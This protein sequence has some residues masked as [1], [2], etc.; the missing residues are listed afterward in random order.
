[1]WVGRAGDR[2]SLQHA[3]ANLLIAQ[4]AGRQRL[5]LVPAAYGGRLHEEIGDLEDPALDLGRFS[6]LAGMRG[7]EA[8]LEPGEILYLPLGW[9]RQARMLEPG[10]SVTFSNFVWPNDAAKDFPLG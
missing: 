7:Y 9:W 4:A 2:L 1:M 6:R 8:I 5:I 3:P 10:A